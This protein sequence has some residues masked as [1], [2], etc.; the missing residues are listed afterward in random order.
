VATGNTAIEFLFSSS[1]TLDIQSG[2]LS[3]AAHSTFTDGASFTGAGV[4]LMNN[5]S[6]TY[7]FSGNIGGSSLEFAAGRLLGSGVLADGMTWTGG[8]M[9][10][11]QSL[12]VGTE[13]TLI[14]AGAGAKSL[15]GA[16]VLTNEGVIVFQDTGSLAAHSGP[17]IVNRGLFEIRNDALFDYLNAG[18]NL[19]F[20]NQGTLRKTAGEGV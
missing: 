7:T 13:A 10:G 18:A 20:D 2:S 14:M 16:F 1:G 17:T 3:C 4:T 12:T 15:T 9:D 8:V 5:G 19:V 6:A 11:A